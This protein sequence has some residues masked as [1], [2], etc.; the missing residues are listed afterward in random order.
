MNTQ[1]INQAITRAAPLGTVNSF[2]LGS[3]LCYSI[4]NG[5]YWHIPCVLLFPTAYTGYQ[6]YKNKDEIIIPYLSKAKNIYFS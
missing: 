4:Q 3:G 5:K 2:L 1:F 6:M